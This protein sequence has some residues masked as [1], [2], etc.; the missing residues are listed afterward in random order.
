MTSIAKRF[1][2]SLSQFNDR[3]GVDRSTMLSAV[4]SCRYVPLQNSFLLAS[5]ID[6]ESAVRWSVP[7]LSATVL[8]TD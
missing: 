7:G 6:A 3:F 4:V 8:V 2:L 1:V 5:L